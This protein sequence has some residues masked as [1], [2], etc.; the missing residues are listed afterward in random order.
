MYEDKNRWLFFRNHGYLLQSC[1]LKT[2]MNTI[3]KG[4]RLVDGKPVAIKLLT[5]ENYPE[6]MKALNIDQDH[7][8]Q[9][10]RREVRVLN[11]VS[12][13]RGVVTIFFSGEIDG[14]P[15]HICNWVKGQSLSEIL[16]NGGWAMSL[17]ERMMII[18]RTARSIRK[19]HDTDLVHR[20]IAPD[21]LYVTSDC[22]TCIIDFGMAEFISENSSCDGK[23]YICHDIFSTGLMLYEICLGRAFFSYGHP[24]LRKE[25][26]QALADHQTFSQLSPIAKVVERAMLCDARVAAQATAD[27]EP[28]P[29]IASFI[30]DL[31][32]SLESS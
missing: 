2:W 7:M 4:I 1:H 6:A 13:Q 8:I 16:M 15:Y 26:V 18:L 11:H 29:D 14:M 27:R 22:N 23:R 30:A 21:H 24:D 3:Y 25:V 17:R 12:Q 32:D 28:Y 19:L 31:R 10:F 20:D 5:L 9:R